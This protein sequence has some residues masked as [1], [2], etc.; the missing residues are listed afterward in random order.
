[1]SKAIYIIKLSLLQH[2][3]PELHYHQKQKI[4]T[5][6]YFVV[7]VYL[8]PWFDAASLTTAARNDISLYR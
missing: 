1:M 6:A 4:R 2:Q 3:L 8:Q 5:M 7:F